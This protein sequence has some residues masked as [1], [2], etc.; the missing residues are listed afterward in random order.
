M[1]RTLDLGTLGTLYLGTLYVPWV[2]PPPL[3]LLPHRT[4]VRTAGQGGT[5][6]SYLGHI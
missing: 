2:H 1:A 6:R 5:F 4:D 3:S